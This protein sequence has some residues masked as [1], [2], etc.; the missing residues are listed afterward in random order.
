MKL[1]P[2]TIMELLNERYGVAHHRPN[3]EMPFTL[4]AVQCLDGLRVWS[5]LPFR[6]KL[7]THDGG[8][9]VNVWHE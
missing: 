5:H 9:A 6:A 3:Y 1:Y 8:L 7:L 2:D 4:Q